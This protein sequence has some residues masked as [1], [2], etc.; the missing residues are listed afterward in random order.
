[1]DLSLVLRLGKKPPMTK[2]KRWQIKQKSKGLCM[3]CNEPIYKAGKCEYHHEWY[4]LETDR[5]RRCGLKLNPDDVQAKKKNICQNC[6]EPRTRGKK[7][8]SLRKDYLRVTI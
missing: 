2:Q 7:W 5:C 4:F 6:R 3:F 8:Y 1:M